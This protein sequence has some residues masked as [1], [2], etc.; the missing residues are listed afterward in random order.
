MQIYALE[1]LLFRTVLNLKSLYCEK[2][3][4]IT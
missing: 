4:M 3:F 1:N 2:Y